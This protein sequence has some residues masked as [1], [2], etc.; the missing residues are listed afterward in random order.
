MINYNDE[1]IDRDMTMRQ[2]G[3][4]IFCTLPKI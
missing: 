2:K 3:G 4:V 1:I